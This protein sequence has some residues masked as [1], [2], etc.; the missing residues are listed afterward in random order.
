[1]PANQ[2]Y[3]RLSYLCCLLLVCRLLVPC[4]NPVL[5]QNDPKTIV[6]DLSNELGNKY[7]D[8]VDYL[9]KNPWM[10]DTLMMEKIS[11]DI[12]FSIVIPGMM[13]Y[14]T[15]RELVE[16][17]P[18]RALYIQSGRKYSYYAT[19][20]FQMKASFAEQVERN[21]VRLKMGPYKFWLSN[22]NKARAER[23]KRLDSEKWQVRYLVIFI[24]IMD[25]RFAHIKW[26]NDEDKA[27]FYAT[28]FDVGFNRDE[29]TIQRY[30]TGKVPVRKTLARKSKQI[31]SKY[32][33]G[34]VAVW[35]MIND[36]H[37]F[38]PEFMLRGDNGSKEE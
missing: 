19:G 27:R 14:S 6:P 16:S 3:H 1:M 23:A 7:Y 20:R 29:R 31:N 33:T 37:R 25:K 5:A 28:A 4:Q 9:L 38:R 15:L 2:G 10:A 11:P 35:F 36:G 8:A 13:R 30:M 22:T 21:Y 12:A 34:D 26:K 17:R 24:K 18:I 32:R